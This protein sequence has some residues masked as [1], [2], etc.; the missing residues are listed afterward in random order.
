M[1]GPPPPSFTPDELR[2]AV[3]LI[4][5]ATEWPDEL[6]EQ[7]A[8][9]PAE[10]PWLLP[11]EVGIA[12]TIVSDRQRRATD[13]WLATQPQAVRARFERDRDELMRVARGE[14]PPP[15]LERS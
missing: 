7:I 15:G 9:A 1:N 2:A 3:R 13:E 8:A 14:S 6:Y 11:Y 5:P 12:L 4:D 10:S